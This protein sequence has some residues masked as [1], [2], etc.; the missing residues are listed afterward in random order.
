VRDFLTRYHGLLPGDPRSAWA[1][2]GPTLRSSISEDNYVA[3]WQQFSAVS[4]TGVQA[5]DGSLVATGTLQFTY[6]NGGQQA[7]QHQFTLVR[8][9]GGQL[10]LD[11]DRA[12]G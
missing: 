8:G 1:L 12:V 6:R 10:L 7:E 9:D 4:L 5:Q 11:S 2:T 3:F